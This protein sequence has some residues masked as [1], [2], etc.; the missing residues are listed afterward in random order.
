MKNPPEKPDQFTVK[1]NHPP[2]TRLGQAL[3]E[4]LMLDKLGF[5]YIRVKVKVKVTSLPT[6]S[7]VSMLVFILERFPSESESDVAFAS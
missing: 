6:S 2:G 1:G 3:P 4:L 5:V 7:I